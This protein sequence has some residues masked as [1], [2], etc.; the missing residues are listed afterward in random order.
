MSVPS[1]PDARKALLTQ[2]LALDEASKNSKPAAV[3]AREALIAE[4]KKA[5]EEARLAAHFES[6]GLGDIPFEQ[7][8]NY[9]YLLKHMENMNGVF[10]E[11]REER[12]KK[13]F[14]DKTTTNFFLRCEEEFRGMVG[15]AV[16]IISSSN[17]GG[18]K[19]ISKKQVEKIQEASNK[20]QRMDEEKEAT[21]RVGCT[22]GKHDASVNFKCSTRCPCRKDNRPCSDN[23][24]CSAEN[25]RN[26][27]GLPPAR[28]ERRGRPPKDVQVPQ[29]REFDMSQ[30]ERFPVNRR[31][32]TS[33]R[34]YKDYESDEEWER[35][36][37]TKQTARQAT[38]THTPHTPHTPRT[39]TP[40]T[41][42]SV[43]ALWQRLQQ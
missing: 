16:K 23:C 30:T 10:E 20:R 9:E 43:S 40:R 41:G 7:Q 15:R 21:S 8:E 25:C 26:P 29:V 14:A 4:K 5:A 6:I 17:L 32:T 33:E 39:H 11:A 34:S 18:Y 31:T 13:W 24:R 42:P 22:C 28:A 1:D 3:A 36:P 2:L 38:H 35:Q 19:E 27:C 37:R 12:N